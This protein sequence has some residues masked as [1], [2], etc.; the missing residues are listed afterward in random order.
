[1]SDN[2]VA[3]PNA[4]PLLGWHPLCFDLGAASIEILLNFVFHSITSYSNATPSGSFSASQVSA[5][6]SSTKTLMFEVTNFLASIDVN[7]DGCH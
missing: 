2:I 3:F 5:A 4:V 1:M 7:P 6:A